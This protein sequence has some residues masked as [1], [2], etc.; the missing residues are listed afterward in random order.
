MLDDADVADFLD[1]G[2]VRIPGAFAPDTAAA[3]RALVWRELGADPDDPATWP[4]PVVT[5]GDLDRP[6]FLTAANTPALHTAFDTLVGA[7]RWQR[8]TTL[9]GFVIRFPAPDPSVVDG[10]H[11]DV[12]FP[13]ADSDPGDYLTWRANVVSR[14]RALLML[15]LFTDVGEA[16]APTRLRVGSHRDVARI[17]HREGDTGLDARDLAARAAAATADREIA[18]ATGAAGDVYLC[19]PFLVH[20]GQPN[21]GTRPRILGQPK[22]APRARFRIDGAETDLA[23]VEQAI[24]RALRD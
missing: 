3:C 2:F 6:P 7:G 12:S 22:L 4:G 11:V 16:D 1:R 17:L 5:L 24:R 9:G 10:W 19:H 23:P 21:R 13:G 20:A 14:D 15:F 18:H 8:R